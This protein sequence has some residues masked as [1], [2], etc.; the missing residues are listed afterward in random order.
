MSGAD[1]NSRATTPLL[2]AFSSTPAELDA[3]EKGIITPRQ[4]KL[5]DEHIRIGGCGT[6]AAIIAFVGSAAFM[7]A[8]PFLTGD[9]P[10]ATSALPWIA[11]TAL[12]MLVI[13][14]IF[15][16]I[17]KRR[18]GR[19]RDPEVGMV[20]GVAECTI[21]E[22]GRQRWKAF[23]LRIGS[24]RF[25]LPTREQYDALVDGGSYR[26]YYVEYPPAHIILSAE[27]IQTGS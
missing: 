9:M 13:A 17:G 26:I 12:L 24:Q 1:R 6:R 5:L 19:L 16:A 4:R 8:L 22:V 10:A 11:G 21:K 14:G 27:R 18:L 23:H 25:Q 15:I 20:E 3:N 2:E 7:I